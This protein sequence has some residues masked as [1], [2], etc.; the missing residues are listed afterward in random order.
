MI[1]V[2][3]TYALERDRERVFFILVNTYLIH[4][5]EV[6]FKNSNFNPER[7]REIEM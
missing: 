7:E 2:N 5:S 4:Y 3:V 6:V 1:G